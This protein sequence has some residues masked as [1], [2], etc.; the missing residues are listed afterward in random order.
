VAIAARAHMPLGPAIILPLSA[1]GDVRG[2]FTV[3]REPGAMPLP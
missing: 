2:V 1:H 3:G